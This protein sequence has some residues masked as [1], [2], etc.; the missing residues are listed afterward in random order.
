MCVNW[1]KHKYKLVHG[2]LPCYT[3]QLLPKTVP[4]SIQPGILWSY[5]CEESHQDA[6]DYIALIAKG[7][8]NF[9]LV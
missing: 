6:I 2:S 8:I 7:T 4:V 9:L 5:N 3:S 1:G